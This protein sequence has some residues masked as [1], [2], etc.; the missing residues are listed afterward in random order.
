MLHFA[1]QRLSILEGLEVNQFIPQT[2]PQSFDENIDVAD[3]TSIHADFDVRR[4][5]TVNKCSNS[6]LRSLVTVEDPC[7]G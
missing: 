6:K 1:Y 5:E 3:V 2:P 7:C 4:P